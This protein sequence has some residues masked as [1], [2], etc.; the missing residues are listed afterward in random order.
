MRPD[1]VWLTVV[2]AVVFV[3]Y[4][5]HL[6]HAGKLWRREHSA[7]AFR[8][9]FIAVMLQVGLFRI[10]IGVAN[11]AWPSIQPLEVIRAVTSPILTLMLL[12]GGIVI[13]WSWRAQAK[14]RKP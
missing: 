1:D 14:W 8:N 13:A 9:L 7:R 10:L 5:D 6:F 3:V 12:S 4:L 2:S 11:R